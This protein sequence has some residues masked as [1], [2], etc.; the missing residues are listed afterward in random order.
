MRTRVCV[1]ILKIVSALLNSRL[2]V[3]L[4]ELELD[5]LA[6][7]TVFPSPAILFSFYP[8]IA[9]Y[10]LRTKKINRYRYHPT[11]YYFR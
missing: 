7:A 3:A 8:W 5:L 9:I 10:V 4:R 6:A 11:R 2:F 1:C